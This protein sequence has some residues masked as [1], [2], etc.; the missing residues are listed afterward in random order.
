MARG[1][2]D[3]EIYLAAAAALGVAPAACAALEDSAPG[4]AAA[5]AA[6]MAAIMVPDLLPPDAATRARAWRVCASLVEARAELA[7]LIG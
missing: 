2:P 4:I 3:P 5:H 7:A 6:G 1:K